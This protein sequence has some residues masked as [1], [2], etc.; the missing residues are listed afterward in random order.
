MQN[1]DNRISTAGVVQRNVLDL[2][3]PLGTTSQVLGNLGEGDS[4]CIHL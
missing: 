1:D 2:S 4:I 3:V